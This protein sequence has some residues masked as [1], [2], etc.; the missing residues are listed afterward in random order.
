M[1]TETNIDEHEMEGEDRRVLKMLLGGRGMRR[2]KL[3]RL[4]VAHL[5]HEGREG[6]ENEEDETEEEGGGNEER[7]IVRLLFGGRM[8]RRNKL[9]KLAIAHLLRERAA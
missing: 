2:S 9:R 7:Q 8:L 4:A 1:E 6:Y 5:L 3:R